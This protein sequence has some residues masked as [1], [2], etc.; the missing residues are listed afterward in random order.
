MRKVLVGMDA[1]MGGNELG[2][3]GMR[4][5]GDLFYRKPVKELELVKHF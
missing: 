5:G 3:L 1:E 4:W 2:L